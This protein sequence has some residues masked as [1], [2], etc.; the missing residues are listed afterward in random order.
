[1]NSLEALLET[2]K[3]STKAKTKEELQPLATNSTE[4]KNFEHKRSKEAISREL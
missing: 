2:L 1:M 3:E 4:P